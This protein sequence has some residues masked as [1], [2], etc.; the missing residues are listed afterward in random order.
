MFEKPIFFALASFCV[1]N[2]EFLFALA[3]LC[4]RNFDFFLPW[5]NYVFKN[6]DFPFAPTRKYVQKSEFFFLGQALC[7]KIGLFF[8]SHDQALC[9]KIRVCLPWPRYVFGNMIFLPWPGSVFEN[10]IS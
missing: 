3:R 7:S 10:P 2:S 4:V 9:S 8:V 6:P 5:P 1:R